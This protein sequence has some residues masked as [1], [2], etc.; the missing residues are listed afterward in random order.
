M[1]DEDEIRDS[2]EYARRIQDSILP[3]EA[4]LRN[5]FPESF[6]LYLQKILFQEISTGL[7]R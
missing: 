6:I 7:K 2:Y 5:V 4:N 3:L 1:I